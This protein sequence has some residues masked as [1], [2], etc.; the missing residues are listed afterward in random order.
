MVYVVTSVTPK[1]T[2]LFSVNNTSFS[3]RTIKG[4]AYT[5]YSL[6]KKEGRAFLLAD[7][8]KALVDYLYFVGLGK[9]V[10]HERLSVRLNKEKINEY[11]EFF[12]IQ[13]LKKLSKN[14]YDFQ[15]FT[16]RARKKTP[17]D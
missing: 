12:E 11:T 8:E 13:Q 7:A 14:F 1:P 3:Y 6:V 9:A 2:R 16:C 5:G 17:N 4:P 10:L 15:I